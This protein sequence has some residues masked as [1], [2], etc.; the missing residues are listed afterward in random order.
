MRMEMA[1]KKMQKIRY[2]SNKKS[3]QTKKSKNDKGGQFNQ[4]L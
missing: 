1:R 3:K 2:L 4:M